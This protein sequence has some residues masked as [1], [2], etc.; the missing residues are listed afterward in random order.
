[1][2]ADA[3]AL[4]C[5]ANCLFGGHGQIVWLNAVDY[6]KV[7]NVVCGKKAT[8]NGLVLVV[9]TPAAQLQPVPNQLILNIVRRN[10]RKSSLSDG[11]DP[12]ANTNRKKN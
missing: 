9:A 4:H 5:R 11:I 10:P 12:E 2:E 7:P 1:M 8:V 6:A 3:A